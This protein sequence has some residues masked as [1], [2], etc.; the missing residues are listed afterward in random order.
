MNSLADRLT[1]S[2]AVAADGKSGQGASPYQTK[3]CVLYGTILDTHKNQLLQRLK[4]LCDPGVTRFQD[5]D[6][7]LRLQP[8]DNPNEVATQVQMRRRL[9]TDPFYWHCRYIGTPEPNPACPTIVRKTIDSLIYSKDMME[10]V[11]CLGLRMAFE[12]IADGY[13]YLKENIRVTVTKIQW[14][15]KAGRYETNNRRDLT[16][17]HLVEATIMLPESAEYMAAAKK[18]REFADQLLPLCEMKK[19]DY[20]KD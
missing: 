19:L 5:H 10:F 7:C 3:E 18:L 6:M 12:Y 16:D 4:G 13:V 2:S 9:N 17:S 8:K 14:T 11:K 1:A 20:W 15:E